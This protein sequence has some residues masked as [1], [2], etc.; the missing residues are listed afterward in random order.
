[1]DNVILWLIIIAFYTPLHFGLP[2]LVIFLLG[3][4]ELIEQKPDMKRAL[5]DSFLSLVIAFTLAIY[6]VS[7][8]YLTLAMMIL[9]L[10][11]PFPVIRYLFRK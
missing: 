4:K 11:M 8:D 6:L 3:D 9:L 2:Q 5:W 10:S 1:M 7:L